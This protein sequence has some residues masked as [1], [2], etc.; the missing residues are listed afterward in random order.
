VPISARHP[1]SDPLYIYTRCLHLP[2][3]DVLRAAVL[4]E[5]VGARGGRRL[6]PLKRSIGAGCWLRA[7]QRQ[8]AASAGR[9]HAANVAAA[10]SGRGRGTIGGPTA[11]APAVCR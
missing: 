10:G 5:A 3:S 2:A 9:Q 7:R 11:A 8:T 1:P 6:K 4:L